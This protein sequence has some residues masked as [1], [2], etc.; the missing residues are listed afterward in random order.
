MCSIRALSEIR[1]SLPER[2][3]RDQ[4]AIFRPAAK[5]LSVF[6]RRPVSLLSVR[7]TAGA[8]LPAKERGCLEGGRSGDLSACS[9]SWSTSSRSSSWRSFWLP[10]LAPPC[11][12]SVG[13]SV[14]IVPDAVCGSMSCVENSTS[15]LEKTSKRRADCLRQLTSMYAFNQFHHRFVKA[16]W[17]TCDGFA[18]R[19][20]R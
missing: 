18:D 4:G 11:A 15:E 2:A 7:K 6:C 1:G 19:A 17:L 8:S 16:N 14:R 12:A 9:S 20:A 10:F 5:R 13:P 3:F